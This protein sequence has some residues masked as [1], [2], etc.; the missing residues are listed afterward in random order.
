MENCAIVG[1]GY[2][3]EGR[4][5]DRSSASLYLE[6]ARNALQDAGLPK[7]DIDGVCF[8]ICPTDAILDG[9]RV[10]EL[11]GISDH[12]NFV[13][14]FPSRG[15]SATSAVKEAV[16]AI[17]HGIAECV[18]CC[19]A[20][21]AASNTEGV[22][23]Q[24][25]RGGLPP[26]YGMASAA[27]IYAMY[28]QRHMH[29]Y[30][31]TTEDLAA[32]ALT[33]REHAQLKPTA[34]YYG[35]PLT[36]EEYL[37]SPYVVEPLRRRDICLVSDGGR[38]VI[39]TSGDRARSL[40]QHPAYILGMGQGN[41]AMEFGHVAGEQASR[42]AYA[43]AGLTPADMQVACLYDCFTITVLM[44]LE[45]FGFCKQ[46]EA[47]A[48]AR[49]GNLKL[50]GKL[51]WNPNGGLLSDVYLEGWTGLAEGVEQIRGTAGERQ[52]PNCELGLVT[53]NSGQLEACVILGRERG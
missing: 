30:G 14:T 5:P 47:G 42:Q 52:V 50:G 4:V 49:E 25:A 12:V 18:L 41:E 22:P 37:N 44:Q 33:S 9:W 32:V 20:E 48:F 40:R 8:Q 17:H 24:R 13:A 39:V 6:A 53:G 23:Y 38:A 2:T 36:M 35:R 15:T 21:T 34:H 28:A 46:G 3:P 19:F 27:A 29:L 45:S 43:M 11:L 1:L 31:T 7:D 51:P 26:A 16:M 10:A